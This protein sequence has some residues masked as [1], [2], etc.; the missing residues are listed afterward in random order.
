MCYEVQ[1]EC[2][3]KVCV[4]WKPLPMQVENIGNTLNVSQKLSHSTLTSIQGT[5]V[6]LNCLTTE[7]KH[8]LSPPPRILHCSPTHTLI[9]KK[10]DVP[11]LVLPFC[12]IT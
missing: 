5:D 6:F 9:T 11:Y 10:L 4:S 1:P 12:L 7:G 8:S 3:L 2:T